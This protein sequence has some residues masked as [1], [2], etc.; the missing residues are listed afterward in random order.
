MP[1][2]LTTLECFFARVLA[3]L[4]VGVL[5]GAACVP[6]ARH[7]DFTL[8]LY[9]QYGLGILAAGL[10]WIS[11]RQAFNFTNDCLDVAPSSL[12]PAFQGRALPRPGPET[13]GTANAV[14]LTEDRQPDGTVKVSITATGL[15]KREFN[16]L[17]GRLQSVPG[18]RWSRPSNLHDGRRAISGD[19]LPGPTQATALSRVKDLTGK[20]V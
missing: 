4:A 1:T 8:P 19:V 10:A 9:M 17:R 15:T 12:T 7:F 20:T 14:A 18:I 2:K 11:S 5:V 3:V 6:I 13:A 16:N